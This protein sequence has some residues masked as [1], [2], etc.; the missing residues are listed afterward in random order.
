MKT[1]LQTFQDRVLNDLLPT[2][3]NDP[4]RAWG[5]DGFKADW[6][7][8][9]EV[10]ATDFLRGIDGGLVTHEHRGLYKAP[11]SKASEQ[12]FW[13]GAKNKTPRPITVWVEPI[14]T[15]AV[16][17]RLH[18]DLGWPRELLGTQSKDWAF[19]VTT[20]LSNDSDCEHIACEV[21]KTTADIDR[22]VALMKRF[23]KNPI[24]H[25]PV[26]SKERNAFRKLQALRQ[27]RPP[28]FW[29]VGPGGSSCAFRMGYSE[30]GVVS[31]QNISIHTLSYPRIFPVQ[32][33]TP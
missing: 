14:I 10:D 7:K 30:E 31:F 21:K 23:G 18:F 1:S 11:R 17:A 27:R 8:I 32:I 19:D 24:A 26:V 2:F 4:S 20:Y 22:L 12:F 3:C 25:Q 15:V 28:L 9:S 5:P 13:S 16:L 29:A 33:S 6:H